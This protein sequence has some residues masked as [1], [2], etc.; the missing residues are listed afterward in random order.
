M[1]SRTKRVRH[2]SLVLLATAGALAAMLWVM[3]SPARALADTSPG[4]TIGNCTLPQLTIGSNGLPEVTLANCT[5]PGLPA[6]CLLLRECRV[7]LEVRTELQ[8]ALFRDRLPEDDA[9]RISD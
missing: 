9:V 8:A 2:R 7:H 1:S 3:G 5:L 6:G 4:L